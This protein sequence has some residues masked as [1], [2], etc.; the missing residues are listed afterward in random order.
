MSEAPATNADVPRHTWTEPPP[1]TPGALDSSDGRWR[2][3]PDADGEGCLLVLL[4][5][6]RCS[7]VWA[8]KCSD[9]EAAK[10]KAER[11]QP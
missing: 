6:N 10:G 11:M 9:I 2:I 1:D 8:G 7:W 3:I 5:A 4:T